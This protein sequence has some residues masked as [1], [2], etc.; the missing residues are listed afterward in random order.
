VPLPNPDQS[1]TP[2]AVGGVYP[3][4]FP[5][6]LRVRR[7]S[8]RST[9]RFSVQKTFPS[10]RRR[11]KSA[12]EVRG[13]L[14]LNICARPPASFWRRRAPGIKLFRWVFFS[15]P[16]FSPIGRLIFLTIIPLFANEDVRGIQDAGALSG[17]SMPP[18][19]FCHKIPARTQFLYLYGG[20]HALQLPLTAGGLNEFH[21][22]VLTYVFSP[23][24]RAVNFLKE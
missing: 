2:C 4:P 17:H 13:E 20:V 5:F 9:F 16:P 8:V 22:Q 10:P 3:L 24:P 19:F 11:P 12:A 1:L 23:L 7:P 14:A 6:P 18:P 15:T 21:P